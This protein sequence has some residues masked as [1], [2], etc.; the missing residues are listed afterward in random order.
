M[1]GKPDP[2]MFY[3]QQVSNTSELY[4][5]FKPVQIVESCHEKIEAVIKKDNASYPFTYQLTDDQFNSMF[6]NEVIDQ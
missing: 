3:C 1:Y 6:L 4:V 5:R 2:V